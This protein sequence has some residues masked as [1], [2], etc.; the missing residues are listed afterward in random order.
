MKLESGIGCDGILT[1]KDIGTPFTFGDAQASGFRG[2]DNKD[3]STC[4]PVAYDFNNEIA[5]LNKVTL[6][7]DTNAQPGAAFSI[8]ATWK[9]EYV[10][11][12][13]GLPTRSTKLQWF[14]NGVLT[15]TITG[16]ACLS[17]NLPAPYATLVADNGNQIVV[18]ATPSGLPPLPFPITIESERLH[19]TAINGTTWD[20]DRGQGDTGQ[21]VHP[22][23]KKAM[24][25]PLPIGPDPNGGPIDVQH[26]MCIWDEGWITVT[27]GSPDCTPG[28]SLLAC[29]QYT[30]SAFDI[31]DGSMIRF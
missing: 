7:W 30:T 1:C 26:Q 6:I 19:V 11:T 13:T 20:V 22:G 21:V 2:T 5:T 9:P 31:G 4:I 29:V 25:N 17:K 8:T 10:S 18:D 16:R 28:N 27:S 24:S 15:P 3:G 12:L 23:G 14:V